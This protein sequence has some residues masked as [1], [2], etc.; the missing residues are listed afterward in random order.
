MP[1]AGLVLRMA[2]AQCLPLTA[3]LSDMPGVSLGPAYGARLPL[4]LEADTQQALDARLRELAELPEVL[5]VELAFADFSDLDPHA[6]YDP[7]Q[8]QRPFPGGDDGAA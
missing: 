8:R 3:A 7:P 4:V 6:D 5:L 2:S 1:V